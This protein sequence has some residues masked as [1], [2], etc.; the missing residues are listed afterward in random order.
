MYF[1]D[2]LGRFLAAVKASR[3]NES[4]HD[5]GLHCF[6][7]ARRISLECELVGQSIEQMERCRLSIAESR[8]VNGIGIGIHKCRPKASA[9]VAGT[10]AARAQKARRLEAKNLLRRRSIHA[11]VCSCVAHVHPPRIQTPM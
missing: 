11:A 10:Y 2:R 4:G 1:G 9:P 8:K 6:H 5:R 3:A 7:F